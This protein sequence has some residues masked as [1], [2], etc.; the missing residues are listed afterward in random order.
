MPMCL[1]P[2]LNSKSRALGDCSGMHPSRF[3]S[4]LLSPVPLS[5]LVAVQS[6]FHAVTFPSVAVP[7]ELFRRNGSSCCVRTSSTS[8][9]SS[10]D[11]RRTAV[12]NA[13]STTHTTSIAVSSSR[14]FLT[15]FFFLFLLALLFFSFTHGVCSNP[16]RETGKFS[17]QRKCFFVNFS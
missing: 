3:L 16:D 13:T 5:R 10:A 8:S 11:R 6:R 12:P 9:R 17:I 1:R 7:R 4:A 2:A 14:S 15:F